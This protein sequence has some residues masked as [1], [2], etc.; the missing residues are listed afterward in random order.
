MLEALKQFFLNFVS[1]YL[2]YIFKIIK[3]IEIYAQSE[4]RNFSFL[5]RSIKLHF[6]IFNLFNFKI[7]LTRAL[8][9]AVFI[10]MIRS[11]VLRTDYKYRPMN[12][13]LYARV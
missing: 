5:F 7:R 4:Q 12:T 13:I 8:S 6:L 9:E 10:K 1:N 3:E 2:Y 11:I